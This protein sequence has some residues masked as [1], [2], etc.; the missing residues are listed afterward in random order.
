M[1]KIERTT[2]DLIEKARGNWVDILTQAGIPSYFFRKQHGPCPICGGKDR[3][4]FKDKDGAGTYFCSQHTNSRNSHSGSGAELLNDYFGSDWAQTYQWLEN[5]LFGG[6]YIPK[7]YDKPVDEKSYELSPEEVSN[8]KAK[9][10]GTWNRGVFVKKNDRFD[11]YLKSRGID[12]SPEDMTELR[13]SIRLI[14]SLGYSR[15]KY[16]LN[17][18][19]TKSKFYGSFSVFVTKFVDPVEGRAINLHRTYLSNESD[20]KLALFDFD[21]LDK[22]GNPYALPAKKVMMGTLSTMSGC[23]LRLFPANTEDLGIGEG[24]ET[25]L[26][27]RILAKEE[28]VD[29]PVWA[30]YSADMMKSL[31]LPQSVID[32]VKRIHVFV[33]HDKIDPS[34]GQRKGLACAMAFKERIEKTYSHITVYLYVPETEGDDWN[35]CLIKGEKL[36]LRCK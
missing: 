12:L 30:S 35:D 16:D 33:D 25:A 32:N 18:K 22:D 29:L 11:V 23:A 20:G 1:K 6:S 9:L 31:I 2:R 15:L 5:M 34:T 3:F 14:K 10:L 7:V 26:A 8:R 19:T 36:N 4:I 28:G 24:I 17:T 13:K 27:G 21:D